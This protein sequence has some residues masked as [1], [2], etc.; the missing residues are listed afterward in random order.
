MLS[1]AYECEGTLRQALSPFCIVNKFN[2]MNEK[3]VRAYSPFGRIRKRIESKIG[4]WK[5]KFLYRSRALRIGVP[6]YECVV[7]AK[8]SRFAFRLFHKMPFDNG[9]RRKWD[10]NLCETQNPLFHILVAILSFVWPLFLSFAS[11][12]F[13]ASL[14]VC[15]CVQTAAKR[16]NKA[17]ECEAISMHGNCIVYTV[18]WAL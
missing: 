5:N 7:C 3:N 17:I 4:I 16:R 10:R 13:F 8:E 12:P 9:N 1:A 2:S 18:H 14:R 11:I 15:V 6:V